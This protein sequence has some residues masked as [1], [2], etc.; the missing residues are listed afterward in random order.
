MA[1]KLHH[2]VSRKSAFGGTLYTSLCGRMRTQAHGMNMANTTQE[3]TC[4]FC[5]A[6][7][8]AGTHNLIN[9]RRKGIR[10]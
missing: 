3:V 6:R 4:A 5:R 1:I 7:I 8:D 10:P 9:G 2:P